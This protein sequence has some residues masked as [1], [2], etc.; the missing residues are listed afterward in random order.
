MKQKILKTL[1]NVGGFAPFHNLNRRK[2]LILTYHRF[3]KSEH[4]Y[5]ISKDEFEAHLTYLAKHSNVLSLDEVVE[6]KRVG[7]ELPPNTTV[8]TI[9]DGYH[10]AYDVAFPLLQKFKTPATLYAI[11]DFL[12]GKVWLWTD[13]MRYLLLESEAGYFSYEHPNGEKVESELEDYEQKSEVAGR[14]NSIL[15]KLPEDEKNYRIKEIAESLEVK[16]PKKPTTEFSPITWEQ[17]REMDSGYVQIESHTVT[18]PI[19]PNIDGNHLEFELTQAKI[20]LENILERKVEHFCYPNGS[21]NEKVEI[22]A[23]DAG[24]KSAVTTEYGFNNGRTN[25]YLLKRIDAASNIANFA[26]SVSGFEHMR[27][28]INL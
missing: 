11:T 28:R 15:K 14:V 22:A 2:V 27:Q 5:R 20:R 25:L 26:Q 12:D 9:D 6:A 7:D 21:L 24:Y 13:L 17:A 1:Y 3:S 18:H 23:K 16:I 19:L 8:I 4:P 10:D